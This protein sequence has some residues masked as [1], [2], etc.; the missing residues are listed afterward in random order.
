VKRK[1]KRVLSHYH[2]KKISDKNLISSAVLV[3]LFYAHGEYHVL[4]TVRSGEVNFH[5]GQACFPGGT[6]QSGDANLIDTALREAG[7]EI[8]LARQDVEILGELDDAVT[9]TSGCVISPFVAFI[10]YPYTFKTNPEEVEQIFSIPLSPLM[11]ERNFKQEYKTANGQ[12]WPIYS[13]EYQGRVVW[14]ATAWIL[15]RFIELLQERGL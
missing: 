15:K 7:E 11:D 9:V 4:F 2:K 3:P 6:R 10:P 5:K 13:Y 12:T 1:I 14:G 8:G